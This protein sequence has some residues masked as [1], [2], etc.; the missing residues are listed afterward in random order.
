MIE[1][2]IYAI[3]IVVTALALFVVGVALLSFLLILM[4]WV[5]L[6]AVFWL[7]LAI[8]LQFGWEWGLAGIVPGLVLSLVGLA[9][10]WIIVPDDEK[11]QPIENKRDTGWLLPLAIGIWLGSIAG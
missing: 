9:C 6:L 10:S 7:P 5:L 8:G 3:M 11:Y 1:T 4:L 2:I